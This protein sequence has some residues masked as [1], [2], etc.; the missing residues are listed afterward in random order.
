MA[1]FERLSAPIQVGTRTLK[2][3]MIMAPMQMVYTENGY[4]TAR[5]NQFY[6]QRAKGSVAMIIVSACRFDNYGASPTTMRLQT[7][8]DVAPWRSFTDLIHSRTD[9]LV[10]VQLYHAG[11]YVRQELI[12]TEAISPSAVYTPFT[13]ETPR[14][15]T[16]EEIQT[17]IQQWAAA[18]GRAKEAGFDLVE[19]SG[20]AGYLISQFL[21][22]LTNQRTDE[23]GGSF[24][25][26]CRF[27]LEVIAAVRQTVGADYPLSLRISGHDLV[28]GSNTNVEAVAFAKLA[29]QA[30]I[31]MLNVTGGWHESSIPQLTGELPM[32]GLAFLGQAIKEAVSIPVAMANRIADPV[33]AEGVL[34]T[35]CADIIA[36]GRPL[37]ADP[38]LPRK[39][40][41]GTTADIRPCV[42]CNEG[43]IA[44]IFHDKPAACLTNG[45][46]G[47]EYL[48]TAKPALVP[49][50]ILVAG[51]GP[52]G[53][54]FAITAAMRGHDVTLWERSEHLGGQ[55]RLAAMLPARQDFNRLLDYYAFSLNRFGVKVQ[56]GK[57]FNRS[58]IPE[59]Y[60]MLVLAIGAKA[61][62]AAFPCTAGSVPLYDYSD[63]LNRSAIAGKRVVVIGGSYIGCEI[64]RMLLRQASLTPDE[65]YYLSVNPI[66]PQEEVQRRLNTSVREVM[67]V[68]R[69]RIGYGY[70]P[71][72]AW[73]VMQDLKRLGAKL[74]SYTDVVEVNKNGV[75]LQ[76]Q[77]GNTQAVPCDCVVYAGGSEPDNE[78]Y[79]AMDKSKPVYLLGNAK[80]IGRA[81]TAI[82]DA[83]TL[84]YEV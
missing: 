31:D 60:D 58:A 63:I 2:N 18:A 64:A 65:L 66:L 6:L 23:Y 47:R 49:K 28:P 57:A 14:A 62:R 67:V 19:I 70:E 11:R 4:P 53:C 21:S 48:F 5:F 59:G 75:V 82:N 83:F 20:S 81:I 52:A 46:A 69:R 76:D 54:A 38:N 55:L 1:R 7:E 16:I 79:D 56:M 12:G 24:E 35:G 17:V 71:G 78:I 9:C 50:N 41:L 8:A 68:D 10:G 45:M 30:G 40:L 73:P 29:E 42:A 27:P 37:I 80:H 3:R 34:A 43:C 36:M 33:V 26:R 84:A 39:V 51:G 61:R 25:N 13:K 72:T 44:R 77:D 74:C 32:A 22:P 15:M